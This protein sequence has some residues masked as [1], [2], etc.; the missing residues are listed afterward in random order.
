M[1]VTSRRSDGLGSRGLPG[2]Q[3]RK[4]KAACEKP[5][6]GLAVIAMAVV[7]D[8]TSLPAGDRAAYYEGALNS[9]TFPSYAY[10]DA[11]GRESNARL[12]AWA[13]EPE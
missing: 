10:L 5:L 11:G 8:T 7:L 3:A 6:R 9:V 1:L 13:L 2:R 4:D 12:E